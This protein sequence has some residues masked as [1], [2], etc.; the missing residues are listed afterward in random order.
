MKELNLVKKRSQRNLSSPVPL[1]G[2]RVA[3]D[4]ELALSSSMFWIE[5]FQRQE[6]FQPTVLIVFYKEKTWENISFKKQKVFSS[7]RKP[8]RN[9]STSPCT[10]WKPLPRRWS[11]MLTSHPVGSR[12][13][14]YHVTSSRI[15]SCNKW[16]PM[17]TIRSGRRT[18]SK[19]WF[20]QFSWKILRFHT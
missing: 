13:R 11:C 2:C 17:C 5:K 3:M 16:A 14:R 19:F 6:H 12:R 20:L 4:T 10:K 8:W 15:S 7:I 18:S 9:L 1:I